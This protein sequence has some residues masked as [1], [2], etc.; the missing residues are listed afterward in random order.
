MR[1]ASGRSRPSQRQ[2]SVSA[3]SCGTGCE[4]QRGDNVPR[5]WAA[6]AEHHGV[7]RIV[8]CACYDVVKITTDLS[9]EELAVIPESYATA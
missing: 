1:K 3:R 9:W 4:F 2:L 6:W 7:T 8:A 5:L